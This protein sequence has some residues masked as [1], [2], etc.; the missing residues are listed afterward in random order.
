MP[1]PVVN[2]SSSDQSMLARYQ[3]AQT[4]ENARYIESLVL[5]AV[6]TPHWIGNSDCFWYTRSARKEGATALT[7][8]YRL[9]NAKTATNIEAFDHHE[10]AAALAEAARQSV[11]PLS[12][13][14]SHLEFSFEDQSVAFDAFDQRWTFDRQGS[15]EAADSLVKHSSQWLVSPDGLKAVFVKDYNLWLK[16][17]DSGKERALTDDGEQYYAYGSQPESRD[18]MGELYQNSFMIPQ[19]PQALWSPDS[20]KLFTL[21]TDERQ[22]RSLPAMLYAPQDDSIAPR[23]VERKCALPGDKHIAHYRLVIIDIE[24][25][26]ETA[27]NYPPLQDAL[28]WLCPFH[29]YMIHNNLT[30]WSKDGEHVYFIDMTR[31][32]KTA[33][34]VSYNLQTDTSQVLLEESSPTY[35]DLGL[36]YEAPAMLVHLPETDEMIWSSERSNWRHLYL[37]DLNTGKLKNT[38]T[39]G[40][41]L[42]R[43]VLHVDHKKRELW[44]QIAGRVTGRNPY[45]RE[46]ARVNIDTGEMTVLASSNHDYYVSTQPNTAVSGSHNYIIGIKTRVDEVSATELRN[47]EGDLVL[48]LET[49]DIAGL[50]D[51]WQWPEPVAMKADDGVTD[52]YGLVCRPTDF[53]ANKKYPVL[54]FSMASPFYCMLPVGGFMQGGHTDPIANN[55]Y[56]AMASF[57]ELGFI[58]VCMEGRGTPYRSKAFNDVGYGSFMDGGMA[59]HV[60]GLRQLGER[61]PFMDLNRVGIVSTDAPGNAPILGL[62]NYPDIYKVG[63]AF[64]P[65]DPNLVRQG[66][67]YCGILK[68]SDRQ[69]RLWREAAHRLE[70]KLLVISGLLDVFFHQSITFQLLDALV[71]ADK[72]VDVQ[73]HPNGGHGMRVRHTQRR[74]FDYLVQHL[75]GVEL[76]K[77]V[78]VMSSSEIAIP[79]AFFEILE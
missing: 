38:I 48:T 47:R 5:N 16:E 34:L 35:I 7:T 37:Y 32:Q 27:V 29:S 65:W 70:G 57:A 23:A 31:G 55:L 72:P 73:L 4:I 54:E 69:P 50:P 66:E 3:R 76:P 56:V 46:L 18:L 63:V 45:Y 39:S 36:D 22:V 11:D 8:E 30:W 60:A 43:R 74:I 26:A 1:D 53:D 2:N 10:L 51:G 49:A 42:V 33:R 52:I 64:T 17:L 20:S 78:K 71:K 21:Q 62:L 6:I 9:V 67:V 68:E 24:S 75:Q 40:E 14:I 28:V 41:W 13:P 79:G 25:A 19:A 59:D 77:N 61:Y 15:I 44:L 58:V 12:L